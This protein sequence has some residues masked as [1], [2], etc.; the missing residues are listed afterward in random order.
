MGCKE[1]RKLSSQFLQVTCFLYWHY[2]STWIS[3]LTTFKVF[4][5]FPHMHSHSGH[6][7]FLRTGSLIGLYIWI[8]PFQNSKKISRIHVFRLLFLSLCK[9]TDWSLSPHTSQSE[10][11]C[12]PLEGKLQLLALRAQDLAGMYNFFFFL[13]FFLCLTSTC[14]STD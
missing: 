10:R 9:I 11:A 14:L 5:Y 13:S 1:E 4:G 6:K 12:W 8:P 2:C 7:I 3:V